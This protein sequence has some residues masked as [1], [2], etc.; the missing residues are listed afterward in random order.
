MGCNPHI[1]LVVPG[2]VIPHTTHVA[3]NVAPAVVQ[4]SLP[5]TF[6]LFSALY[7]NSAPY[8]AHLQHKRTEALLTLTHEFIT[9]SLKIR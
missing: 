1:D 8:V 2:G 9:I 7:I 3:Q 6:R 4:S 5:F